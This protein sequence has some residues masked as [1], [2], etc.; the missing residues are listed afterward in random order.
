MTGHCIFCTPGADIIL[1]NLDAYA[2]FDAHPVSPGHLLVIPKR[3]I[4]SLFEATPAELAGLWN[5][6]EKAK[7]YLAERFNPNGYNIGVNDGTAAGQTIMHLH[8]HLIP[9]YTGDMDDPR[10]GVRGVI[11]G[12]QKY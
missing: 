10:G 1:E 8:I 11:P 12:R 7:Q 6:L 2:R 3:H 9:R 5:L 4:G